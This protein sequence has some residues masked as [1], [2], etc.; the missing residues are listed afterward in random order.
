MIFLVKT[1]KHCGDCPFGEEGGYCCSLTNGELCTANDLES[2][3]P[4]WCPFDHQGHGITHSGVYAFDNIEALA[5]HNSFLREENYY[6]E[7]DEA[8]HFEKTKYST[9]L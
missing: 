6:K 7:K 9:G 8:D 3:K 1:P 5:L 2:S 4:D